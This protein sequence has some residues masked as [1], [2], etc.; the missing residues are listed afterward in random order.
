MFVM[1]VYTDDTPIKPIPKECP[2]KDSVNATVNIA[3][4]T[5]CSLFYSCQNGKKILLVCPKLN[6]EGDRLFFNPEL[7][8]C[9]WP[10]NVECENLPEPGEGEDAGGDEEEGEE[11]AGEGEEEVPPP[12]RDSIL[13]RMW[14]NRV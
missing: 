5:N 11:E 6:K 4:E 9:D 1:V 13:N 2:K 14:M 10:E 3:H 7:Q 8:V 12:V